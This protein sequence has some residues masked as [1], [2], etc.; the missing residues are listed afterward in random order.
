MYIKDSQST[1]EEIIKNLSYPEVAVSCVDLSLENLPNVPGA[2][3]WIPAGVQVK[4]YIHCYTGVH[5]MTIN[6]KDFSIFEVEKCLD[7]NFHRAVLSLD[8]R[9]VKT[10]KNKAYHL[11]WDLYTEN[12]PYY[13]FKVKTPNLWN[14]DTMSSYSIII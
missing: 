11:T 6:V 10:L 8:K 12:N 2:S 7:A 4:D 5:L 14:H 9:W 13:L 3:T 1:F